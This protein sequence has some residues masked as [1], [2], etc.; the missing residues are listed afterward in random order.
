[1]SHLLLSKNFFLS[2][3]KWPCG[4]LSFYPYFFSYSL[5]HSLFFYLATGNLMPNAVVKSG[6]RLNLRP[7]T[8]AISNP[9]RLGKYLPLVLFLFPTGN[10]LLGSPPA[11]SASSNGIPG[12]GATKK[13]GITG[14]TPGIPGG[15]IG[16]YG[17][18]LYGGS[19]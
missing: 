13:G 18:P 1:M 16:L 11:K 3:E 12:G 9:S 4:H 17:G 8:R 5:Y 10:A 14:G 19:L 2:M 7:V 15:K 6:S